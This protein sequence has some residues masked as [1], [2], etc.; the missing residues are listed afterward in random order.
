MGRDRFRDFTTDDG[1]TDR[2]RRGGTSVSPPSSTAADPRG[3]SD[4]LHGTVVR[5][6][7]ARYFGFIR[8]EGQRDEY[9]YHADDLENCDFSGLLDGDLVTFVIRDSKK[10]PRAGEVRRV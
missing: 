6:V 1:R 2:P 5:R 9:F 7:P 3:G 4:R 10:G 8:V